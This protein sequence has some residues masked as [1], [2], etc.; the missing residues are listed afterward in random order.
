MKTENPPTGA[1]EGRKSEIKPDA[2]G[3]SQ[4]TQTIIIHNIH[5]YSP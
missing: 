3:T 2:M 4:S 1:V 5:I